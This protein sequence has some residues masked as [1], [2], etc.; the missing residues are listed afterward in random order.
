MLR[1]LILP[2][3]LL[4]FVANPCLASSGPPL[5]NS[6]LNQVHAST[7]TPL[8]GLM[9]NPGLEVLPSLEVLDRGEL[10]PAIRLTST[11]TE[12]VLV[13]ASPA[14]GL[15][16]RRQAFYV[17]DEEEWGVILFGFFT[18]FIG[19]GI[20]YLIGDYFFKKP[21]TDDVIPGGVGLLIGALA[22]TALVIGIP[23]LLA[24]KDSKAETS[25]Q[26]AFTF[27]PGSLKIGSASELKWQV[28]SF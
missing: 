14:S 1:S 18:P 24:M 19:G 21:G 8:S 11:R 28:M 23:L 12:R 7:F 3:L 27:D 17:D 5:S 10:L 25:S 9:L 6:S 26:Q 22:A 4:T 20:G 16:L 2:I 15:L 13:Y